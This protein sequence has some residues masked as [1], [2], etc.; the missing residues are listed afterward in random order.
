MHSL[1]GFLLGS[2]TFFGF[3]FALPTSPLV[4]L[5]R[6][7]CGTAY[8]TSMIEVTPFHAGKTDRDF[9]LDSTKVRYAHFDI[10]SNAIGACQLE[11]IFPINYSIGNAESSQLTV[12][13]TD[14]PFDTTTDTWLSSPQITNQFGTVILRSKLSE[15]SRIVVNSGDCRSMRD[16]KFTIAENNR[17]ATIAYEQQYPVAGSV[18]GMRIVHSC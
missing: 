1:S 16:F 10:P 14:R 18:A 13:K 9:C 12:W 3:T 15:E 4:P 17:N 6:R 11:F 8:P 7:A 2:A 5:D